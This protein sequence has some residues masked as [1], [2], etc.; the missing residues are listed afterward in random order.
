LK[1]KNIK[2]RKKQIT[3]P[4]I[5]DH[6]RK[7]RHYRE[8]HV[9]EKDF[10]VS[11]EKIRTVEFEGG[12]YTCQKCMKSYDAKYYDPYDE[13]SQKQWMI[14]SPPKKG[15]LDK[16][17][18]EENYAAQRERY[19]YKTKGVRSMKEETIFDPICA[20]PD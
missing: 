6:H 9:C 1:L 14:I 10:T 20:F 8:C 3:L 5:E 7:N 19:L 12:T 2:K 15:V 18:R 4:I 13:D 11:L 16:K 17:S